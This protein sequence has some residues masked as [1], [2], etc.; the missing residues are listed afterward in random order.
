MTNIDGQFIEVHLGAPFNTITDE[1]PVRV[2]CERPKTVEELAVEL[3]QISPIMSKFLSQETHRKWL[4][5]LMG[6]KRLDWSSEV[7]PGEV[8]HL[9][10][11]A[12]AG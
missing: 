10:S 1:T 9:M 11:P 6:R 12:I 3:G 2:P 7:Q 5:F 8:I 4:V